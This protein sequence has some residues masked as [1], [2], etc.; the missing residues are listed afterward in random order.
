MKNT[1][2]II[3]CF[4]SILFSVYGQAQDVSIKGKVID[5]KGLPIP[6]ASVLIKG[7]NKATSSDFDGNYQ[8]KAASNGTLLF[9]FIGY[10]SVQEPIKGRTQIDVTMKPSAEALQEVVVTALGIKREQKALGYATQKVSGEALTKVSGVDVASSL[11]GKVAGLLV[12]NTPDFNGAPV[13]TVRGELPLLVI[14]GVPYQ[15]KTLSDV[16]S[17]DIESINVLKGATASALYGSRGSSGAILVTTKNGSTNLA[18]LSVDY[19]NNTMFSA[20]FLALPEKQNVYGRGGSNIYD[21]N[22]DQSWGALMDG[23]IRNQWDPKLKAYADYPYVASGKD[24][25]ENF[26]EQGYITNNNFN[27]GYKGEIAS[28]RGSVNWTQNTGV[29]PNQRADRYTYALGGDIN[30]DKFKFSSNVSYSRKITPNQSSNSYTGYDPM[31]SL[32]IWSS[33]DFNI[34]DYKDYWIK[35]NETQNYTLKNHN[36]PYFNIWQRTNEVNRNIFNADMTMS[37]QIAD[38]LKATARAGA[39]TYTD[40]GELRT[41][42]GSQ[43]MTGNT[44]VPGNPYTWNGGSAGGY[45]IGQN[46]GNSIN[47]DFILDGDVSFDKFKVEYLAGGT[48][49]RKTDDNMQAWTNG[50]LSVPAFYSLKAS[51]SPAGVAT[52]TLGQQV[53]SIYG[54]AALSYNKWAYLEVTGRNDWSSTMVNTQSESYFYPSMS[55]SIVISELLPE[56][57]KS[58]LDLLKVRDSWTMTKTPA[59]IYET[60][61]NSAFGINSATWGTANGAYAPSNLY[62]SDLLPQ[63]ATTFEV[64]L[65]AILFKNRLNF[66]ITYYDKN[67]YDFLKSAPLS[68]ASGYTGRFINIDEEQSRRGWEI[69]LSGAIVKNQDWQWDM[70][71]NWSKYARYYT[72]IDPVYSEKKAWVAVGERVD[73]KIIRDYLRD[74]ATGKQIWS[75]GN[76]QFNPYDT[77]FGYT[78]PDFIWGVNSTL[79]YKDFSLFASLDGVNGGLM[80]SRTESYMWQSGVHPDSVTPERALDVATAGSKNYLGDGV[81]VVS[82]T[83]TYDALGNITSDTRVYATNDVKSTYKAYATA[84]HNSSA[85]GGQGTPADTYEKTFFKLRELSLTYTLPRKYIQGW[86]KAASVSFVGQNV[87]L[88]A[89]DFKYSDPDGSGYN[90]YGTGANATGTVEDFSDPALRYLGGNIKITF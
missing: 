40:T 19:A 79:R 2:L 36:N 52:S 63:S 61:V 80:N 5:E 76:L 46:Q 45:M 8:L 51:V 32:L 7:T 55:M 90:A 72:Q 60:T 28:V 22:S 39:D 56:S 75:N 29:Y 41:A 18:G 37:Y 53:N 20:G 17:E 89:K 47:A 82:G 15:N 67:L 85:W 84:M 86:A 31:Y 11:T 73:A 57:T 83:F 6:G 38:W 44:G 24:N 69:A 34:L 33:T 65:Q 59:G 70:G 78:D 71:V 9:S 25:F 35:P 81:K 42:W 26:L 14:D 43:T 50:G 77:R 21:K 16:S 49:F 54:R 3:F 88:W 1:K 12:R 74:P 64:G 48:I 30:L 27:V 23:T 66:D 87:F 13:I 4:L 62:G 58:W 68:G 10:G